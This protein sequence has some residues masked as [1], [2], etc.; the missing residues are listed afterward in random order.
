MNND[1]IK[2]FGLR[3]TAIT[4]EI[5]WIGGKAVLHEPALLNAN[6]DCCTFNSL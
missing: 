5:Q 3:G 6:D 1:K 2:D 4:K